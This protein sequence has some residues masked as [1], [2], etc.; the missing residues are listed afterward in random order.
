MRALL[1]APL[2]SSCATIAT[3]SRCE[4]ALSGLSAASEIVSV[5]QAHGIAP[6]VAAKVGPLLALGKIGMGVA[7]SR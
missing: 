5:L 7:C 2:L 1:L 6:D 4:T 3:P